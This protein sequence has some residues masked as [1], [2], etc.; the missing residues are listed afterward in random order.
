MMQ[1]GKVFQASI[2]SA[3]NQIWFINHSKTAEYTGGKLPGLKPVL[4]IK[5]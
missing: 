2:S 4:L 5:I 1:S 3:L